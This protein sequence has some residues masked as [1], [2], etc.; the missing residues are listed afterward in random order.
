MLNEEYKSHEKIVRSFL[1][2]M[3]SRAFNVAHNYVSE[4]FKMLFPGGKIFFKIE[5]MIEWGKTRYKRINK[6]YEMF[7]SAEHKETTI[8]YCNGMLSGEWLDG[9][10]FNN[11]RYID[12]FTF[13]N[14]KI[15]IQEVWNDLGEKKR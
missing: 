11:I 6:T 12:K 7:V 1:D 13:D 15:R 2:A 4:D 10:E 5:E 3:E 8:V 14:N 9:L